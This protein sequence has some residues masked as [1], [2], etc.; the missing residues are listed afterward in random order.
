MNWNNVQLSFITHSLP[1][2]ERE[3]ERAIQCASE[4]LA[5]A[6]VTYNLIFGCRFG[7]LA[8]VPD[9]ATQHIRVANQE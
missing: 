4:E 8:E 1:Q 2:R 7:N 9:H 6:F 3:R 5:K